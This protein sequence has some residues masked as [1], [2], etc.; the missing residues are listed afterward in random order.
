MSIKNDKDQNFDNNIQTTQNPQ[1]INMPKKKNPHIE[2][3]MQQPQSKLFFDSAD[4][5]IK[6]ALEK[7]PKKRE[8]IKEEAMKS[9]RMPIIPIT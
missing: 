5:E 9:H 6:R 4:Y 3:I 1:I 7:D 2:K 8:Q